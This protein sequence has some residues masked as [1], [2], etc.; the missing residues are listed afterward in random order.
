MATLPLEAFT[1]LV[2]DDDRSNL[3]S[4]CLV[5]ERE[6]YHTARAESGRDALEILR[7]E[8]VHLMLTDYM[9]PGM[10]GIE[11]LKTASQVAPETDVVIITA[12][13]TIEKAVEAIKLG[14]QDFLTKPLKRFMILRA[15]N[16]VL[17]RQ[18]LLVENE[19]LRQQLDE[20]MRDREIIGTSPQ[21]R[22]LLTLVT[23][24]APTSARVLVQGESGTGKE[25]FA[26]AV[27]LKSNRKAQPF[28]AI[29][30]AAIPESLI[31]SE[32]FGHDKGAFTGADQ[33]KEGRFKQADG[34]TLFLDEIGEMPLHLQTKLL[35]VI[36][37]MEFHRVGGTDPV[38]VDVRVV[39]STNR[40]LEEEVREGNF[41][42]DLFYRLS[43]IKL[44]IPPLRDREDDVPL[45][46][47]HFLMKYNRLND[48]A[49][50]GIDRDA[51]DL[52]MSYAWPGNV[53]ELENVMERAVI[54]CTSEMIRAEDLPETVTRDRK[55]EPWIR[56]RIGTPLDRV[57]RTL[58]EETLAWTGGDKKTAAGILNTSLRTIYRRLEEYDLDA[59]RTGVT[60]R[61]DP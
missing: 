27:H 5:L 57:E 32:L 24:V 28:I 11:L 6:G 2:V 31:E 61:Q 15:V 58:I 54:L 42:E 30:C 34:G 36:Q 1:I 59:E 13:G 52:L 9:M 47:H 8:R 51:V 12:Y 60:D 46:A 41:R 35:R 40:N 49:V 14:A 23:Q 19:K 3:E 37:E 18:N 45:L 17:E 55:R 44:D 20:F 16:K 21:V 43:V 29:N 4:V 39:A 10:D 56:V 53:R 25:L 38:R 22:R 33:R 48:K 50:R 26:R 7:R